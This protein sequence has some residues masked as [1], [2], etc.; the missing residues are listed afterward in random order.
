MT[1]PARSSQN[2]PDPNSDTT[3]NSAVATSPKNPDG[4]GHQPFPVSTNRFGFSFTGQ[5]CVQSGSADRMQQKEPPETSPGTSTA[6]AE[7]YGSHVNEIDK[8]NEGPT[9]QKAI[10][11]RRER[12]LPS[13]S[14][15][16]PIKSLPQ[17]GRVPSIIPS[18]CNR[19]PSE[20]S[21]NDVDGNK[22]EKEI[23]SGD[24]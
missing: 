20:D 23:A 13:Y 9:Y 8:I 14:N 3:G 24:K 5:L 7:V 2:V 6:T 16:L 4:D 21:T 18:E 1:S 17:T 19:S 11:E 22:M 10:L 12:Y 15:F